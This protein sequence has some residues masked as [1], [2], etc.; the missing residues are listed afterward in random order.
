MPANRGQDRDDAVSHSPPPAASVPTAPPRPG[1]CEKQTPVK[2]LVLIEAAIGTARIEEALRW[3]RSTGC[4][5][6]VLDGENQP[7]GCPPKRYRSGPGGSGA[8]G[9]KVRSAAAMA[10]QMGMTHL[11]TLDAAGAD[12]QCLD[13]IVAQIKVAP[14]AVICGVHPGPSDLWG[15][16]KRGTANFWFRVQTG[17][18]L[19]ESGGGLRAYPLDLLCKIGTLSRR[20]GFDYEMLVRSAWAGAA[21]R[22][23]AVA[24][25]APVR[26]LAGRKMKGAE[27]IF[28]AALN[29]HL[30]MRSIVPWPHRRIV[31]QKNGSAAA[32]GVSLLHPW[33]SL[34]TLMGQNISAARLG[35]SV[36][37]GVFLGTL[38]LI[39]FHSIAILFAAGF[40]RLSKVA[41]LSASQLCMPPLVPALCIEVG[42]Y[43]RHG[44]LLTEISLRTLGYE[45]LDR[46]VEWL[47]GSLLLAPVLGA[48][49]GAGV[50]LT[51][52]CIAQRSI[53][54]KIGPVDGTSI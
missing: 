17:V 53:G 25:P 27:W 23:V 15:R 1:P 47:A 39:G 41:A 52:R 21:I 35:W 30:T 5:A 4:G 31:H 45:A 44:A 38:P 33:Q 9:E 46:L 48:L 40:F 22:E 51:A 32:A 10:E 36:A 3:S 11:I 8:W 12:E 28:F 24:V 50:Y 29:I 54:G 13:R 16:F 6:M 18:R 42:H 2:P 43:L 49:T 14:Q 20:A 7:P 26:S 37:L 34:K 19:K